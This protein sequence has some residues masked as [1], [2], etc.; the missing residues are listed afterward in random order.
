MKPLV[1]LVVSFAFLGSATADEAATQRA[2]LNAW[3]KKLIV[4]A[5]SLSPTDVALEPAPNGVTTGRAADVAGVVSVKDNVIYLDGARV[6]G[7][8]A[9]VQAIGE[10]RV[11]AR[12]YRND[13]YTLLAL[14]LP[15]NARWSTIVDVWLAAAEAKIETIRLRFA[16]PD[17]TPP[18]SST[19][20]DAGL[21]RA[22][23]GPQSERAQTLAG[24]LRPL[25]AQCPAAQK[26]FGSLANTGPEGR[27]AAFL[28]MLSQL[29][30]APACQID[31]PSV[32]G[33]TR[34]MVGVPTRTID[35]R[36]STL[37]KR[38]LNNAGTVTWR[39]V[40]EKQFSH[41]TA[42]GPLS[43]DQPDAAR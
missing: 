34:V 40:L 20:I 7:L 36:I 38:T 1:V 29:P 3:L 28:R 6:G 19:P 2:S 31:A 22:S 14:D 4:E 24:I 18:F 16:G 15:G 26:G 11:N 33:I 39:E 8:S 21:R 41:F 5:K 43:L 32:Q 12:R 10:K 35:V 37:G 9:L 17:V 27:T 23:E 25:F 30:P 42:P 13:P